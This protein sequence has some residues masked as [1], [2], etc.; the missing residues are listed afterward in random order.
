MD[1][2][3]HIKICFKYTDTNGNPGITFM[4]L[5]IGHNGKLNYKYFQ[6]MNAGVLNTFSMTM[7]TKS[8]KNQL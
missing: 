2:S 7:R 4:E 1:L 3:N 8:R 5:W 6:R